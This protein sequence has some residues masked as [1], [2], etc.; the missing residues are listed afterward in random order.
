MMGI[1]EEI[2]DEKYHVHGGESIEDKTKQ[3]G[4]KLGQAQLKLGLDFSLF[5]GRFGLVEFGCWVLFCRFDLKDLAKYYVGFRIFGSFR[6]KYFTR[7]I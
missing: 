6:F 3:A 1:K 2:T 5:F 7:M 4:A